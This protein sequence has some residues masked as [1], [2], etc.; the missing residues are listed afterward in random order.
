MYTQLI[1]SWSKLMS[2]SP[3]DVSPKMHFLDKDGPPKHENK[4]TATNGFSL[5]FSLIPMRSQCNTAAAV[6]R[7]AT[8]VTGVVET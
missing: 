8:V 7:G 1:V 6:S 4:L 3:M 5:I 2:H